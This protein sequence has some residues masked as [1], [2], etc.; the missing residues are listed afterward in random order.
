[1]S[2]FDWPGLLRLALGRLGLQPEAFWRLTPAEF[3][4]ML[5][6]PTVA[7]PLDRSRLEE[8]ARLWPD[9][10]GQAEGE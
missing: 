9:R 3:V 5:G 2:G 4:L 10:P 6:E 7:R 1:M 8:L